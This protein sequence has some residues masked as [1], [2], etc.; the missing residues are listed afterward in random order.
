[1]QLRKFKYAK[2]GMVPRI[3]LPVPVSG[4]NGRVVFRRLRDSVTWPG[5]LFLA[6]QPTQPVPA[7]FLAATVSLIYA[8]GALQR[9]LLVVSLTPFLIIEGIHPRLCRTISAL[10]TFGMMPNN[11]T[12]SAK[13]QSLTLFLRGLHAEITLLTRCFLFVLCLCCLCV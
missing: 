12:H 9:V 4:D 10:T 13:T 6:R 11:V 3:A 5:G 2:S 8:T 7:G 1:M